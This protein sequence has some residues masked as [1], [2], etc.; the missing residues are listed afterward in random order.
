MDSNYCKL[1]TKVGLKICIG[2]KIVRSSSSKKFFQWNRNSPQD[3]HVLVGTPSRDGYG[4]VLHPV[5]KIIAHERF[6]QPKFANDIALLYTRIEI[7]FNERTHH[8][9]VARADAKEGAEMELSGW[10]IMA[11]GFPPAEDLHI[12][13]SYALTTTKCK[14]AYDGSMMEVHDSHFC[15]IPKLGE[16]PCQVNYRTVILNGQSLYSQRLFR[17]INCITGRCW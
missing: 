16:G 13:K 11:Q 17:L 2:F 7:E 8:V 10:G 6:N 14:D 1:C 12:M 9:I 5:T 15:S 3:I 4:G